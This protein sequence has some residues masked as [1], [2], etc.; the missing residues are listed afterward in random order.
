MQCKNAS[1]HPGLNRLPNR[2]QFEEE[3]TQYYLVVINLTSQ[4]IQL[5][6]HSSIV[7]N[8]MG[9]SVGLKRVKTSNKYDF[10]VL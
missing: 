9:N 4:G 1:F 3:E 7:S 2:K 6:H 5:E 10:R 8:L